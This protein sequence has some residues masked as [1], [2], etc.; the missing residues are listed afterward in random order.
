MQAEKAHPKPNA[1]DAA[2]NLAAVLELQKQLQDTRDVAAQKESELAAQ[3]R[4]LRMNYVTVEADLL[5][6]ERAHKEVGVHCQD[7][8][9]HCPIR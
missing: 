1:P 3:V 4:Q 6:A 7:H 5:E 9:F 2:Q 8:L